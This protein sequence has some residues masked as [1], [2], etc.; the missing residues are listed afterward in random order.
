MGYIVGQLTEL[1]IRS[2]R[3][4]DREYFL[5][6][7]QIAGEIETSPINEDFLFIEHAMTSLWV[8]QTDSST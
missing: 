7:V 8:Y 6:L 5:A 2:A 4:R 3:H 1:Q